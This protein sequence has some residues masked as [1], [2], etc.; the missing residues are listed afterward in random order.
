MSLNGLEDAKVVEAYEA[1]A[2]EPGGWYDAPFL[3]SL[4]L[5]FVMVALLFTQQLIVIISSKTSCP[6]L[7]V[8]H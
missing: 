6:V 8:R 4:Y 1:A 2:T 3:A 5:R 7:F